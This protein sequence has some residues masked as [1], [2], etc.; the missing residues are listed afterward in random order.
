[1]INITYKKI[2]NNLGEGI[3]CCVNCG[4]NKSSLRNIKKFREY[5]T[6]LGKFIELRI[7]NLAIRGCTNNQILSS[8]IK[9]KKPIKEILDDKQK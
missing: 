2:S 1:M 8:V 3:G 9:Y 7:S 5:N 6:I 4:V